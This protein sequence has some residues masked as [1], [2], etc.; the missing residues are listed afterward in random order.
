MEMGRG[1]SG[2][3]LVPQSSKAKGGNADVSYLPLAVCRWDRVEERDS[4]GRQLCNRQFLLA[5]GNKRLK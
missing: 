1:L 3:S 5:G 2:Y 4:K